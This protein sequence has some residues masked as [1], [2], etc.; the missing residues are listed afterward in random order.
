MPGEHDRRDPH[1]GG[2]PWAVTEG[3]RPAYDAENVRFLRMED[4]AA[5]LEVGSGDY[6]FAIDAVLG[7]LGA[8]RDEVAGLQTLVSN[9]ELTGDARDDLDAQFAKL[10]H[11]VDDAWTSYVDEGGETTAADVHRALSTVANL[12][13]WVATQE[14][15]GVLDRATAAALQDAL[16]AVE[17][18]LSAASGLL[19][20]AVAGLVPAD[21]EALP[22][23]TVSVEVTV[24]NRGQDTL[25]SLGSSVDAPAG[26]T[27]TPSGSHDRTVAPGETAVH[28]YNVAIP[29]DADPGAQE[30]TGSVTYQYQSAAATLP[31]S[32]TLLVVPAVVVDS[33][34]IEPAEAQPGDAVTVRTVLTNRSDS[35]ATGTLGY[36]VPDGW[37][38]PPPT[39]FEVPASGTTEI[40]SRIDV[41]LE[42]TEGAAPIRVAVGETADEQAAASLGVAFENPPADATDHV[43]LGVAASEQ[44]HALRAS[45]A[46]GTNVEA[47]LTRRYTNSA[48]PGGWFEMQVEVPTDGRFLLR[49]VE[50]FD[51]PQFK[52]YD[53][54]VDGEVV[55]E[56]RFRRT[57]GGQG[58]LSYQFLVEEP[59]ASA[60]GV[61][62]LRFQDVG[63]DYDPSIAD[64]W[65]IPAG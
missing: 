32:A 31:V 58:S 2:E 13:R 22:G 27:V 14:R 18:H 28:R 11:E 50:T 38:T 64:L 42:V 48:Q 39:T 8:A 12:Q 10:D 55:H 35:A 40:E 51:S 1:A 45:P 53:V 23:S 44:A 15:D 57:A 7:R 49:S 61:A 4:G 26:W 3:G 9:G 52:T 46:S 29:G 17:R 59:A 30:L 63:A 41:P 47:G 60:D 37:V 62:T 34:V 5:V 21:G 16:G 24:E 33:V 56:R 25:R 43:D 65:V 6:A 36:E 19:V 54:L 20:G